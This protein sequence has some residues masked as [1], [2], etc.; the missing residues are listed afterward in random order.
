MSH[1]AAL[2]DTKIH[3]VQTCRN[4]RV[5]TCAMHKIST[6]H[7]H[8]ETK[9]SYSVSVR[10]LGRLQQQVLLLSQERRQFVNFPGKIVTTND[11]VT[12]RTSKQN[13][14]K[15]ST[16]HQFFIYPCKQVLV[17]SKEDYHAKMNPDLKQF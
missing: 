11:T 8:E 5:N 9:T 12:N 7:K 3:T 17:S 13:N 10:Y 1:L 6:S 15:L 16:R 14:D 2:T 4:H